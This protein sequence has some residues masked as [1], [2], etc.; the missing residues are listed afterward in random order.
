MPCPQPQ[1][2]T[3][4][5]EGFP[6]FR[7][8]VAADAG[9]TTNAS[10]VLATILEPSPKCVE[11]DEAQAT[12]EMLRVFDETAE[13]T[14][15]EGAERIVVASMDIKALYTSIDQEQS[16]KDTAAEYL[17]SGLNRRNQL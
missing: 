12:E 14:R 10:E 8:L 7:P 4:N 5:P 1:G 3:Q 13:R 17:R 2:L 6:Q 9:I 15:T 11:G 16:A